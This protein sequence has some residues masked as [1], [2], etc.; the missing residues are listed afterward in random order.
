[1]QDPLDEGTMQR[2]HEVAEK[3][4]V[5]Y[6]NGKQRFNDHLLSPEEDLWIRPLASEPYRIW[7]AMWAELV[8]SSQHEMSV[9][10]DV[11]YDLIQSSS[12]VL[13]DCRTPWLRQRR[14]A[15]APSLT[16]NCPLYR[17][18][19]EPTESF[20]KLLKV[21]FFSGLAMRPTEVDDSFV[22]NVSEAIGQTG[23]AM[24]KQ[25]MPIV[26][27][28]T[29][30]TLDT[31]KYS[32]VKGYENDPFK[33]AGVESRSL[34]ACWTLRTQLGLRNVLHLQGGLTEWRRYGLPMVD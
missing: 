34:R 16:A 28:D 31:R 2:A 32:A 30:G 7:K 6:D 22:S 21:L 3:F 14:G 25:L 12:A 13:I 4:Y 8:F 29:G 10:P 5:Q 1:M 9:P 19:Q 24:P 23:A 15:P 20:W 11:A 18:V 17:Q 27:C 26:F 33:A